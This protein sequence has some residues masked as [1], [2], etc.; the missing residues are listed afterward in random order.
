MQVIYLSRALD[1][2]NP[3][4]H[5]STYKVCLSGRTTGHHVSSG[6]S[7]LRCCIQSWGPALL[8]WQASNLP[9]LCWS[10]L[11]FS[12]YCQLQSAVL[13]KPYPSLLSFLSWTLCWTWT[14]KKDWGL[15][16]AQEAHGPADVTW[17]ALQIMN[18]ND[19]LLTRS[20]KKDN[21]RNGKQTAGVKQRDIIWKGMLLCPLKSGRHF[22]LVLMSTSDHFNNFQSILCAYVLPSQWKHSVSLLIFYDVLS[23]M[24]ST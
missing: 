1:S 16:P 18:G 8:S 13:G 17:G 9:N 22:N 21:F 14:E 7:S 2:A 6:A 4:T 3:L 24:L 5:R 10:F 12:F 15:P 19:I 20:L 11:I 23:I